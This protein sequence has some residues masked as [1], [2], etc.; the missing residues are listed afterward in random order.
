MD[1]NYDVITFI[2]N[3]V[4]QRRPKV[5]D[6]IKISCNFDDVSYFISY[7]YVYQNNL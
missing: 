5:A 4:I 3:T 1:R 7:L 6:I 2:Q